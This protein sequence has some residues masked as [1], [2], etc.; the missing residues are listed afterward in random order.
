MR[1]NNLKTL[2]RDEM[3]NRFEAVVSDEIRQHHKN[4]QENNNE[5]LSLKSDVQF[6]KKINEN[7]EKTQENLKNQCFSEFIKEKKE[8]LSEFD[9]HRKYVNEN[10]NNTNLALNE[11]VN[12]SETWITRSEFEKYISEINE[13]ILGAHRA[14]CLEK[15]M[16]VECIDNIKK[17]L[18]ES[19]NFLEEVFSG[20][21][22]RLNIENSARDNQININKVDY[23]G[24]LKE[25][26]VYK[27]SM[28]IIEKKIEHIY[29]QIK[30]LKES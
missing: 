27:K 1:A 11:I 16:I 10:V 13:Q 26:K 30:R 25:L 3:V 23:A 2:I 17:E 4:I 12:K 15:R 22:E 7:N 8:I 21:F 9:N 29:E 14:I 20:K 5:I 24:I 6:L 19:I 28:F 18:I